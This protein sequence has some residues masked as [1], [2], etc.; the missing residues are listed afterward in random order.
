MQL[1]YRGLI[2]SK[3]ACCSMDYTNGRY[4]DL[5]DLERRDV[6]PGFCGWVACTSPHQ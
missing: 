4:D 2:Q 3:H 6:W 5:R 1:S